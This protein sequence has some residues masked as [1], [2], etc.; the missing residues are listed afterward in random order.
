MIKN[1]NLESKSSLYFLYVCIESK[2]DFIDCHAKFE[3][4]ARNDNFFLD[5]SLSLKT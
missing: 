4:F 1:A 2:V 5:S 3:N